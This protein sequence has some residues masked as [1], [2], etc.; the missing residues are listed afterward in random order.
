LGPLSAAS[1]GVSSRAEVNPSWGV[2]DWWARTEAP[3]VGSSN[4]KGRKLKR[5]GRTHCP[6]KVGQVTVDSISPNQGG[7]EDSVYSSALLKKAKCVWGP[8]WDLPKGEG[9]KRMFWVWGGRTV[10]SLENP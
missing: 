3:R 4:F 1:R 6:Q 8:T 7:R 2:H 10:G 5:R 9:P